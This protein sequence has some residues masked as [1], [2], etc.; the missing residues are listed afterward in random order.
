MVS[1]SAMNERVSFLAIAFVGAIALGLVAICAFQATDINVLAGPLGV[2]IGAL[3]GVASNHPR[4]QPQS[5]VENASTV[6]VNQPVDPADGKQ[7]V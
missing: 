5:N 7:N 4:A 3:A 1:N 6:T 2:C